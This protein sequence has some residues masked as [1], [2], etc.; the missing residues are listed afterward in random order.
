[1]YIDSL[2]KIHLGYDIKSLISDGELEILCVGNSME[3]KRFQLVRTM[4][5]TSTNCIDKKNNK[6]YKGYCPVRNSNNVLS[7]NVR[8]VLL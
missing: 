1:M 4:K 2:N 7:N 8:R 3:Q 5:S 6:R